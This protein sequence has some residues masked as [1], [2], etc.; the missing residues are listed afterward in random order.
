M[1]AGHGPGRGWPRHGDTAG[2]IL[3]RLAALQ[4]QLS[5]IDRRMTLIM[6]GEIETEEM[7]MATQ[8]DVDALAQGL[9]DLDATVNTDYGLIAQAL[10]NAA[11]QNPGVDLSEVSSA[12]SQLGTDVSKLSGLAGNT[13]VQPVP[14]PPATDVPPTGDT[15]SDTGSGDTGG[16]PADNPGAGDIG[17]AG[18]DPNPGGSPTE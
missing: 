6:R 11:A 1:A 7:I 15:G 5:R 17:G 8:A 9:A 18:S 12:F 4:S 2:D 16:T 3:A 14:N 10:Q 13:P